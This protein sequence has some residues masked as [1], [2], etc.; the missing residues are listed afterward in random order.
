MF[1]RQLRLPQLLRQPKVA[2]LRLPV[3]QIKLL[4]GKM[5]TMTEARTM[6][7]RTRMTRTETPMDAQTMTATVM[8]TK[9][10]G[11]DTQTETV[12]LAA[13]LNLPPTGPRLHHV[14][15]AGLSANPNSTRMGIPSYAREASAGVD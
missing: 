6:T 8:T 7:T 11:T 13:P 1:N 12:L 15:R 9:T 2:I 4:A 5:T 3:P 14:I 10:T